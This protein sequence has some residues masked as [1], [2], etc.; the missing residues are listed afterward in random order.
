MGIINRIGKWL[1]YVN[2]LLFTEV[3]P[4]SHITVSGSSVTAS[5][6][7]YNEDA[8]VYRD[9]GVDFFNGFTLLFDIK[10]TSAD[11]SSGI[12]CGFSNQLDDFS[13]WSGDY[14]RVS[15]LRGVSIYLYSK[16]GT[17][18]GCSGLSLNVTYYCKLVR[19]ANSAT[20]T[21][22]I[23]SDS[24]RVTLIDTLARNMASSSSKF[25]YF[26]PIVSYDLDDAKASS[27]NISNF[28]FV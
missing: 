12:S 16:S 7:N 22:Y 23:Y 25:R 19:V 17:S 26:Y 2:L 14:I 28:Q 11:S 3:D 5:S 18:D 10:L 13:G 9:Y 20:L 24:S 21:L 27:G 8:Y 15:I 6:I 1:K 4:N